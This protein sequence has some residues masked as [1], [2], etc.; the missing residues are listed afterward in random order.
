MAPAFIS[1]LNIFYSDYCARVLLQSL[2]SLR[3]NASTCVQKVV[4][5]MSVGIS[6]ILKDISRC[7]PQ[8]IRTS[9]E[10]AT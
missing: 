5:L 8:F 2:S 6:V 7:F 4:V 1:E 3:D 10:T 9:A